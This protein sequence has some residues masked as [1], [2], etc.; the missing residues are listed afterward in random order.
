MPAALYIGVMGCL[1]SLPKHRAKDQEIANPLSGKQKVQ[2]L[3]VQVLLAFM[4]ATN[5]DNWTDNK[6]G[7]EELADGMSDEEVAACKPSG[8]VFDGNWKIDGIY[9]CNSGLTGI[10]TRMMA[11]QYR[12]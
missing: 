9:L 4:S 6:E 3:M 1:H 12:Q 11:L 2:V 8:V 7:W 10:R 5:F